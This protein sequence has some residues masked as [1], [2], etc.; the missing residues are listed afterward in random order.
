MKS[1]NPKIYFILILFLLSI[2]LIINLKNI[3]FTE[4]NTINNNC[5]T[6][7]ELKEVRG[8]SLYPLIKSGQQVEL[9]YDYYKCHIIKR[10]DV[11]AYNYSGNSNSIIKI[12]KAIPEDRL[13]LEKV[14]N[15]FQII[16]NDI[17]LR[18]SEGELYKIDESKIKML[19]L[20]SKN[21]PTL[22]KDTYLIL[23]NQISGTLDST[24]F[25]M[26]HKDNILGKIVY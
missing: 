14:N 3:S 7:T 1:K 8:D 23:G 25:G 15:S 13:K 4:G 18:D 11:V 6:K 10:E 2:F 9:L 12:I 21:Y 19:E 5:I 24:K 17:S 22:P 26:I 20:Y 16:V